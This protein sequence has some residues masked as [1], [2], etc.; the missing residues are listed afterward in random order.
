MLTKARR[1]DFKTVDRWATN[2]LREAGAIHECD[3]HGCAK[4]RTDAHTR[5]EALRFARGEPMPGLQLL[6]ETARSHDGLTSGVDVPIQR[7]KVRQ[8]FHRQAV[9]G[10]FA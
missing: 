4:D 3:Q 8:S 7:A 2:P 1:P 5:E 10:L 9:L 6:A